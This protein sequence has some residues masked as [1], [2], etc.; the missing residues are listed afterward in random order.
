MD[1]LNMKDWCKHVQMKEEYG[2][3]YITFYNYATRSTVLH[4]EIIA[5]DIAMDMVD[6]VLVEDPNE[7]GFLLDGGV[8][9]SSSWRNFI[10]PLS[11]G[12]MGLNRI[13]AAAKKGKSHPEL[14]EFELNHLLCYSIEFDERLEDYGY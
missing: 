10:R 5:S 11:M 14:T 3:G 2:I 1:C 6:D 12:G 8:P 4:S 9:T 13:N 7:I